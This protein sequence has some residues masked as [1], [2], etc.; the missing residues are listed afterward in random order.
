[1]HGMATEED[2]QRIGRATGAMLDALETVGA[3]NDETIC[4]AAVAGLMGCLCAASG[5]PEQ[6]LKAVV[7]IAHGI[8]DGTLLDP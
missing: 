3:H 6:S 2:A 7:V 1:M 5:D 8:I 4:L